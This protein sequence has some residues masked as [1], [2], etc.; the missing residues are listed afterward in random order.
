MSGI[1]HY[2]HTRISVP[3]APGYPRLGPHHTMPGYPGMPP[4]GYPC[5]RPASGQSGW[6]TEISDS[7]PMA[8]RQAGYPTCLS[9]D[10]PSAQGT[11][12]GRSAPTRPREPD[13]RAGPGTRPRYPP[14]PM[15]PRSTLPVAKLGLGLE[16]PSG[17]QSSALSARLSLLDWGLSEP[18]NFQT[19]GSRL[20]ALTHLFVL[21]STER[22]QWTTRVS[23]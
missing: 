12:I 5:A 23:T 6:E 2:E 8:H 16:R 22:C 7:S 17:D 3:G 9:W 14:G 10:S 4:P 19:G 18:T 1:S 21:L 15:V 11:P 20:R 13:I